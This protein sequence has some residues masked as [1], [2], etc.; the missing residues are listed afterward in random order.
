[1]DERVAPCIGSLRHDEKHTATAVGAHG[2]GQLDEYVDAG[3][4]RRRRIERQQRRQQRRAVGQARRMFVDHLDGVALQHG[5]VD[6]LRLRLA[7]MMLDDQQARFGHL[8]DAA[9][10][11]NRPDHPPHRQLVVVIGDAQV[12]TGP[13]DDC[14]QPRQRRRFERHGP[15]QHQRIKRFV[16][17]EKRQRDFRRH[18]LFTAQAGPERRVDH[19]RDRALVGHRGKTG[20]APASRGVDVQRQVSQHRRRDR[21]CRRVGEIGHRTI[22]VVRIVRIVRIVRV[23]RVVR[24]V[25]IVRIVL[26]S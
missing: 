24:V 12:H 10:L 7:A 9:V 23:V 17:P 25:Q 2:H 19:P 1:M 16:A 20:L 15:L 5:D 18:P 6:E 8:D 4:P 14:R 11:R 22:I 26:L 3:G 13:L 21:S